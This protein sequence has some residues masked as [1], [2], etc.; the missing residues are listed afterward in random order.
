M[1]AFVPV[2][3][4]LND[5]SFVIELGV[6]HCEVLSFVFLSNIPPAIQGLSDSIKI[7]ELFVGEPFTIQMVLKIY[8]KNY[9]TLLKEIEEDTKRWKNIPCS[10]IGRI[11]IS[12]GEGQTLYG[13]THLGNIKN[14]PD[15]GLCPLAPWAPGPV[16]LEVCSRA[17]QPLLLEEHCIRKIIIVPQTIDYHH[18]TMPAPIQLSHFISPISPRYPRGPQLMYPPAQRE[19]TPLYIQ[20]PVPQQL[21]PPLLPLPATFIYQEQ[22]ETYSHG[23]T[24]Y[25]HCDE[26][27]ANIGEH[28]KKK[29]R[30]G[31]HG[32]HKSSSIVTNISLLVN[33]TNDFSSIPATPSTYSVDYAPSTYIVGN[34]T[35][36][37][38]VDNVSCTYTVENALRTKTVENTLCTFTVN[39]AP[40][41]Y[42]VNNA[43]NSYI[44]DNTL[45]IYTVDNPSSTYLAD[46]TPSISS[47]DHTPSTFT[48]DSGLPSTT[49]STFTYDSTPRPSPVDSTSSSS[50]SDCASSTPISESVPSTSAID[51]ALS[52]SS[53]ASNSNTASAQ[54]EISHGNKGSAAGS[55]YIKQKTGGKQGKSPSSNPAEKGHI[56]EHGE[57]C[58]IGTEKPVNSILHNLYPH[59]NQSD[60]PVRI[61]LLLMISTC[62]ND[63]GSKIN[64]YLL[65]WDEICYMGIMKQHKILKLN[66]S[67]KYLFRVA[68][69]NSFGLSEFSEIAVF[70]TS[71]SMPPT[72]SPPKLKEAGICNLSL[73]WCAPTNINP[74]DSLTYVLEMEEAGSIF[75][76]ILERRI[77]A[78]GEV[79]YTTCPYKPGSPKKP[80]IKGKIYAHRVKIGWEPPKDNGGTYISSYSLEVRENSD[81]WFNTRKTINVIH[82]ISKRKTKNHMI[83]SLDAEK[84]FDKKQHPFLIETLQTFPESPPGV[85]SSPLLNL[86]HGLWH[87]VPWAPKL[88]HVNSNICEIKWES[89]EP[90]K[91]DPIVYNLQL[92]SQ[93]GTDVNSAGIQEPWGSYSPSVLLSTHKQH[94]WPGK[95]G[96]GKRGSSTG[97]EKDEKPRTE[98]SDDT[99]VL[100]IVI[101]FALI[102]ILCAVIIQH[103]LIN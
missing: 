82:H 20:E 49:D 63:N 41:T 80:Y 97:E 29:M 27:A 22:H 31:Q 65:E 99:F 14:T 60:S 76:Y 44:D 17:M 40:S 86:A 11:N 67:T 45:S 8:P 39:N 56:R 15:P 59:C 87:A 94:P 42:T 95:G 48:T 52:A 58:G 24:N 83:L 91:G 47:T 30:E 26:R 103:F 18:T 25:N 72:P 46:N 2:P 62:S 12:I 57:S 68:A 101:G 70:H 100:T 36:T 64:N 77:T 75:A 4:C 79:K 54:V 53:A 55:G 19:F 16:P 73:E 10:W 61:S 1:S 98:M 37:Y 34:T 92:I 66:A 89:L 69:K 3:C 93:K 6:R 85:C 9:R 13:L 102:V 78:S 43:Q 21:P 71:G 35:S 50:I 81:G 74:N 32:R 84:A 96:G 33:K 88:Q 38:A 5:H 51:G 90:I 23:R 28:M 7:L